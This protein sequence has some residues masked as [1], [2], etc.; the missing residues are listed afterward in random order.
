MRR[1]VARLNGFDRPDQIGDH[2]GDITLAL[3][4]K[5]GGFFAPGEID[6]HVDPRQK[7]LGFAEQRLEIGAD[8]HAAELIQLL[9]QEFGVT[10]DRVQRVAQIVP[11]RGLDR[12]E[13]GVRR[14]S[15]RRCLVEQAVDQPEQLLRGGE[16]PLEV[17]REVDQLQ[18]LG[19]L[20]QQLAIA[21]QRHHRRQQLLAHVGEPRPP[22][23]G[24]TGGRFGHGG[25]TPA[26]PVRLMT[27]QCRAGVRSSLA[28]APAPPA[29]CRSRRSRRPGTC[30]GRSTSH[31]R[32]G[33]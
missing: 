11:H 13:I 1:R 17:G 14:L 30:P 27:R 8:R 7:A 18:P 4:R 23:A 25:A 3:A 19:F 2:A 6:D 31:A 12:S 10:L 24:G 28:A 22:F 5:L 32:S 20:G 33:R 15:G 21:D 9:Q 16:N 26:R 29:W